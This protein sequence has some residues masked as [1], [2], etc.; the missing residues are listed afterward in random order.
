M[1]DFITR[2][3]TE[4]GIQEFSK[5][6][7]M[8][9]CACKTPKDVIAFIRERKI[10]F[11]DLAWADEM[12][13]WHHEVVAVQEVSEARLANGIRTSSGLV[14]RPDVLTA[15]IA[16]FTQPNTVHLVCTDASDERE[17]RTSLKA[18][19]LNP[20]WIK[21]ISSQVLKNQ[22]GEL[23][24]LFNAC[25]VPGDP[26]SVKWKIVRG[27]DSPPY[28]PGSPNSS[29]GSPSA[30]VPSS[31]PSLSSSPGSPRSPIDLAAS[32]ES[33]HKRKHAVTEGIP[34]VPEGYVVPPLLRPR[35]VHPTKAS[36]LGLQEKPPKKRKN[37]EN[38]FCRHCGTKETP[39]WRRG[40]DGRKSLCN[41]CGLHYSKVISARIL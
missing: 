24:M 29:P 11:L 10:E 40:P 16:L 34:G 23:D 31:P 9:G 7:V 15:K 41:A 22:R 21:M 1:Y 12:G 8:V 33:A 28:S 17:V 2:S 35:Q 4:E 20:G 37:T 13:L 14:L 38:L 18:K 30:T 3:P 25:E 36:R 19:H 26:S 27:N 39:E 6:E 5:S 32:F